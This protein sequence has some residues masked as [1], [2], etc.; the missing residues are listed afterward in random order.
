MS[1]LNERLT[2]VANLSVVAGIVFLAAEMRQNTQAIQ[3]QTRDSITEKQ[4]EFLGWVATNRELAAAES[5]SADASGL[6][7]LDPTDRRMLVSHRRGVIREWEN[8]HYQYERGLFT[9]E[10]FQARVTNWRGAMNNWV[11]RE[12]WTNWRETYAPSFRAEIDR[13]VAEVEAA[14]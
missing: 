13:I 12:V 14:Q 7:E 6:P 1:R 2:L 8:S 10:E 4:M 3:A 9:S 5:R 11:F